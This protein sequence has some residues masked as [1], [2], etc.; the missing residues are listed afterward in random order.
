MDKEELK[1]DIKEEIKL[2]QEFPDLSFMLDFC[3][4]KE[5][6]EIEKGLLKILSS[7]NDFNHTFEKI[8]ERILCKQIKCNINDEFIQVILKEI[9]NFL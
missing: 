4:S 9:S 2:I 3:K 6:E 5:L 1:K 8:Q 7:I